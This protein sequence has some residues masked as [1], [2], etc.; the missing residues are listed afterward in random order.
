M[1]SRLIDYQHERGEDRTLEVQGSSRT[2]LRQIHKD[3]MVTQPHGSTK[4]DRCMHD[5]TEIIVSSVITT[6]WR[7]DRCRLL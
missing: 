2:S 5:T 6:I 3:D 1:S 7:S 4:K